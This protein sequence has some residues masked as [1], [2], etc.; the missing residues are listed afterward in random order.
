MHFLKKLES[1]PAGIKKAFLLPCTFI[2]QSSIGGVLFLTLSI[3]LCI[4][5][6]SQEAIAQTELQFKHLSSDKGLSNSA[7]K[8]ITQDSH[9]FLWIS[10]EN[11][12]NRFDGYEMVVFRHVPDDEGSL[13]SNDIRTVFEDKQGDIWVG[14]AQGLHLLDQAAGQFLRY[15]HNPENSS[16]ISCDLVNVIYEVRHECF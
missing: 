9:G 1:N 13:N 11:G 5:G 12:L 15:T 3:F 10:T 4:I 14:T 16:S 7:V 2:L 8:R 6:S